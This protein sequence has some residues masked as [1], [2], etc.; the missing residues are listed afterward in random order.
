MCTTNKQQ[1]VSLLTGLTAT[2]NIFRQKRKNTRWRQEVFQFLHE[3]KDLKKLSKGVIDLHLW[4][5]CLQTLTELCRHL[6]NEKSHFTEISE[7][8]PIRIAENPSRNEWWDYIFKDWK[9]IFQKQ[10][11]IHSFDEVTQLFSFFYIFRFIRIN[12]KMVI[13]T[14]R[15]LGSGFVLFFFSPTTQQQQQRRR[16]PP[17]VLALNS[18]SECNLHALKRSEKKNQPQLALST[19]ERRLAFLSFQLVGWKKNPFTF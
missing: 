14:L 1:Q 7:C 9:V 6:P 5:L 4:F 8:S 13:D 15:S 18:N 16:R 17:F 11:L 10:F 2:T 3:N 12:E 19:H